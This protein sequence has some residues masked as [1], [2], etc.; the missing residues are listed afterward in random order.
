MKLPISFKFKK[1][2]KIAERSAELPTSWA[3][4]TLGQAI[5]LSQFDGNRKGAKME[6][7]SIITGL[8]VNEVKALSEWEHFEDCL[9]FITEPADLSGFAIPDKVTIDGRAYK[10]PVNLKIETYGQKIALEE[11]LRNAEPGPDG[12]VNIVPMMAEALA[13][14]FYPII[15]GE[16]F[17]DER[18]E[19]FVQLMHQLPVKYAYPVAGFFL[20]KYAGLSITKQPTLAA[21]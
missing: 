14:Y 18:V 10:V 19:D 16:P 20:M 7:L 3:D 9:A 2:K 4:I 17:R 1:G 6:L 5:A 8:P 13:I 15:T 12:D 21:S 11:L